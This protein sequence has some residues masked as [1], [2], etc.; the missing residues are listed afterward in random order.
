M[1]DDT[2]QTHDEFAFADGTSTARVMLPPVPEWSG[3][4]E[5][6]IAAPA[7]EWAI[8]AETSGFRETGDLAE[9]LQWLGRLAAGWSDASL[10]SIGRSASRRE[11][12]MLIVSRF[13]FEPG[14]ARSSGKAVVLVQSGIHAGEMDG[15]DASMMLLRD[16]KA[17]KHGDL[18]DRA[19]LLFVPILNVDGFAHFGPFSRINQRGPREVGRNTNDQNLN[20]NRDFGKLDA[21]ETRA[22]VSVLDTWDPDLYID[23]HVTDGVDYR[24][25]VTFGHAAGRHGWSPRISGWLE[26][27]LLSAAAADLEREGHTPGPLI[28]SVNERDLR[29][30]RFEFC[31]N[32]RFAVGYASLRHIPAILVENHSLKTYRRRLSGLYVLLTSLITGVAGQVEALRAEVSKDREAR[33]ETIPLGWSVA[34]GHRR[35]AAFKGVRCVHEKLVPSGEEVP[36]WTGEPDDGP[37]AIV[38]MTAPSASA[39]R[40]RAYYIP[41]HLDDIAA[42]L[43]HHG[44]SMDELPATLPLRATR[45]FLKESAV[46]GGRRETGIVGTSS[47]PVLEGHVRVDV[48]AV[49]RDVA[50]VD[51]PAG[52]FRVR[53]DQ[54]LGDLAVVLLE[55]ESPDS[56]FQW[57]F[58]LSLFNE[59]ANNEP[60]V[61]EPLGDRM[62]RSSAAL[63]EEFERRLAADA[64]FA[65]SA[66]RRRSWVLEH[67]PY[68]DPD[69]RLYPILRED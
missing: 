55:P 60:Y 65:A 27:H 36:R 51:L 28:L 62:L 1:R 63:R 15:K 64:G 49:R 11:I 8:K 57:G 9:S 66:E 16:L 52:A 48:G 61:L 59:T 58:M 56:F 21:P 14:P 12:P 33:P 38:P 4:S 7:D 19:V 54:P 47:S 20:L 6:H 50:W 23:T 2:I 30:G 42:R 41:P 13:G 69:H 46:V 3:P 5:R 39:R 67:T 37:V 45:T 34:P 24:Y 32:A 35:L 44:L 10:R 22:L 26:E 40:P 31:A 53:T 18:L 43:R 25:D 17:G 68:V 29:E